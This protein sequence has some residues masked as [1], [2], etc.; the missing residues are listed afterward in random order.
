MIWHTTGNLTN[1]KTNAKFGFGVSYLPRRPA[2]RRAHRRRQFLHLQGC[3]PGQAGSGFQVHQ[4]DDHAARA[5]EWSVKTGYVATSAAAYDASEMKAYTASFPQ[6]IVARDQLKFAVSE[7][8]THEN[9]RISK[10][11]NDALQAIV[12][13]ARPAEAALRDAQREGE[14]VLRDFE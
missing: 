2:E 7:L 1:I 9:Q 11:F 12:T 8:T 14:R 13:G 6:A 3:L 10:I 4:V 5:A